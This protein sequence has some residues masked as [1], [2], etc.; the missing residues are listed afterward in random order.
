VPGEAEYRGYAVA[1]C[2]T[3]DGAFYQRQRVAVV[4]GGDVALEEAIGDGCKESSVGS[5]AGIWEETA[6]LPRRQ[7]PV[8]AGESWLP[9][10]AAAAAGLSRPL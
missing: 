6:C 5:Q 7:A 2:A 9:V 1:S 8:S 10:D 4:G 3:C